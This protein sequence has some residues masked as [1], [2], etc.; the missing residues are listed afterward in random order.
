MSEAL[1]LVFV[2]VGWSVYREV[3]HWQERKEHRRQLISILDSASKDSK[4]LIDRLMS[5]NY[6][7]FAVVSPE[8]RP[9]PDSYSM[10]DE[11]EAEL[12]GTIQ[13]PGS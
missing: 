13:Y 12:A 1:I 10:T 3:I 6:Q 8:T 9:Q 2:A 5:R 11:R 7:E 4:S